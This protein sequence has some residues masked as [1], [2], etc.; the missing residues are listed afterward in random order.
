[1]LNSVMS[2]KN[3]VSMCMNAGL[4][5]IFSLPDYVK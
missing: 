5:V 1:M 2:I 4:N 3:V